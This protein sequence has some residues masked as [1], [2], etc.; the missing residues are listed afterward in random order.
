MNGQSHADY[1]L[2]HP[3][4]FHLLQEEADDFATR[5]MSLQADYPTARLVRL[6]GGKMRTLS[7]MFDEI[8]AAF[9]FPYYFGENWPALYD[10]LTDLD[11]A[12]AADYL[13]MIC[14]IEL[15]LDQEP[16]SLLENLLDIFVQVNAAWRGSD[17]NSP[18]VSFRIILQTSPEAAFAAWQR[19]VAANHAQGNR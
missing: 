9:Q 14:D 18:S 7:A 12:R 15:V 19:L 6:R 11:W 13:L 17:E 5:Y 8:G 16:D 10:C 2:V 3:E 4:I 1:A